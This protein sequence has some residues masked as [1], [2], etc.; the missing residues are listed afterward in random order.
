RAALKAHGIPYEDQLVRQG[1]FM[2]D[3][4]LQAARELLA[5]PERPTAIFASNDDMAAG[6]VMAAHEMGLSVPAQLSV[7][8]FDDTYIARTVWPCLTTV[9]QPSYGLAFAATDLLL[10]MLKSR[11]T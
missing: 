1:Y 3:S 2:F 4:G 5:L 11:K 7:A 6:A 9:H 8:G 10:Q